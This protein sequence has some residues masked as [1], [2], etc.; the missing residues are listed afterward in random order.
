MPRTKAV[1]NLVFSLQGNAA[2]DYQLTYVEV[3]NR[4]PADIL[5]V[6]LEKEKKALPKF[7]PG[8]PWQSSLHT[9]RDLWAWVNQENTAYAT[10][11]LLTARKPLDPQLLKSY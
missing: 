9:L 10:K 2:Q 11:R 6:R 8:G 4:L 5:A 7:L 1:F 3:P